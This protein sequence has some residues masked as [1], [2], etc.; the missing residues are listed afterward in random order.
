MT[1]ASYRTVNLLEQSAGEFR[2]N[3]LNVYSR[4]RLRETWTRAPSEICTPY[5]RRDPKRRQHPRLGG[6]H[7]HF[8]VV[9]RVVFR[10]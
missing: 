6:V 10:R 4:L 5:Q 2:V 8:N 7:A 9:D 3:G 1:G